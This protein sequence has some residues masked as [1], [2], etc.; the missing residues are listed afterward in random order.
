MA[1]AYP[2]SVQLGKES[3]FGSP[4]SSGPGVDI[5]GLT[6]WSAEVERASVNHFGDPVLNEDGTASNGFGGRPPEMSTAWDGSARVK[7]A[8]GEITLVSQAR[9]FGSGHSSMTDAADYWQVFV[10]RSVMHYFDSAGGTLTPSGAPANAGEI[11]LGSALTEGEVV[12][13]TQ[14][15]GV[16]EAFLCTD[17]DGATTATVAPYASTAIGASTPVHRGINL[18]VPTG[19]NSGTKGAS[20]VGK[21]S[22][23]KGTTTFTGGRLARQRIYSENGRVMVE[24]TIRCAYVD[25]DISSAGTVVEPARTGGVVIHHH[26]SGH[27]FSTNAAPQ[28]ADAGWTSARTSLATIERDSL[29]IVFEFGLEE[30]GDVDGAPFMADME[31]GMVTV[32]ASLRTRSPITAIRNDLRDGVV[33]LWSFAFGP[34]TDGSSTN[35]GLAVIIPGGFL[36]ADPSIIDR[37]GAIVEQQIQI[38]AGDFGGC[39]GANTEANAMAYIYMGGT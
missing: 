13:V 6:L 30:I 9:A 38:R 31:V 39:D 15:S 23:L 26:Q 5:S 29:E 37:S 1:T 7:R 4:D 3:A 11:E 12:M 24:H 22:S 35:Q 2:V 34:I 20:L 16:V 28:D 33:R 36:T 25:T 21:V 8:Q 19:A 18:S 10:P 17:W 27:A 14:A 32:T